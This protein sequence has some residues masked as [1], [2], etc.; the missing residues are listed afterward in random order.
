MN[1][2][3]KR[4]GLAAERERLMRLVGLRLSGAT[5]AADFDGGLDARLELSAPA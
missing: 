2:P 4:G 1:L 5:S 3:A